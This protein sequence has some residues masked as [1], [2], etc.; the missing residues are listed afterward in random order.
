MDYSRI[1]A[2]SA[3]G[4]EVERTRLDVAAVNLANAQT[5]AG[6]DGQSYRPQR[7]IAYAMQNASESFGSLVSGFA[8]TPV[9]SVEATGAP[10]HTSY[11]PGN[12]FA[13]ARGLVSYPGVD[14]ATE[15]MTIMSA[16]RAYEA[17]VAAMNATRTL[18]LK[19]LDIGGGT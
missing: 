16:M 9:A 10:D 7:V 17:N 11:E 8:F 1:F 4:M 19:A 13:D 5:V 15:M 3:A 6:P 18:A 12:P 14:S 2:V